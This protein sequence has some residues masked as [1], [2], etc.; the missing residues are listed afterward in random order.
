VPWCGKRR[1][2]FEF[3][4]CLSRACVGKMIVFIYKWLK[5]AVFR[6]EVMRLTLMLNGIETSF[7]KLRDASAV[8]IALMER[9]LAQ[10]NNSKRAAGASSSERSIVELKQRL[11]KMQS[12]LKCMRDLERAEISQLE[13][14]LTRATTPKSD[15]ADYRHDPQDKNASIT[16]DDVG[17]VSSPY[18][19]TGQQTIEE[20][21][22]EAVMKVIAECSLGLHS[23][24]RQA[25]L[26]TCRA[27]SHRTK[28]WFGQLQLSLVK[29]KGGI[30]DVLCDC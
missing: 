29:K 14:A 26:R 13:D 17:E 24:S 25:F 16:T 11:E 23:V 20:E 5:N 18:G 19:G 21:C 8:E 9:T 2:F 12:R 10:M 4:L 22:K 15:H 30:L 27:H 7:S 6:R 3:S 28:M 1:S